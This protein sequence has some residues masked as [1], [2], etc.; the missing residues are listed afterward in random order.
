MRDQQVDST[1]GR[2]SASTESPKMPPPEATGLPIGVRYKLKM[3]WSAT[4]LSK[5]NFKPTII[6]NA[7]TG[8]CNSSPPPGGNIR[9][10]MSTM[11]DTRYSDWPTP[12]V[13][14]VH[15]NIG[16]ILQYSAITA[17]QLDSTIAVYRY[18]TRYGYTRLAHTISLQCTVHKNIGK[19][20][21]VLRSVDRIIEKSFSIIVRLFQN[22]FSRSDILKQIYT[23]NFIS[24]FLDLQPQITTRKRIG[25][26]N[27]TM[28]RRTQD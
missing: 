14:T 16:I 2:P 7:G 6:N 4:L 19:R 10:N 9:Q 18:E 1:R 20:L 12:T 22:C 5:R 21:P 25:L 15:K 8:T 17:G 23:G 13:S 24:S 11:L 3:F 27:S 28:Q 26:I